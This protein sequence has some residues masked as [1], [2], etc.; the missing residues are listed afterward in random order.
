[1]KP[2]TM[3]IVFWILSFKPAF[4]LSS[5]TFIKR[6]FSSSSLLAI[7]LVS[8]TYLR[9]LLCL[10]AI[11]IPICASSSVAYCWHFFFL[12]MVLIFAPCRMSQVLQALCL[13]DLIPWI[14]LSLPLYN[15]KGFDLGHTWMVV[16]S[17]T[18]FTFHMMYSAYKLN[19]QG[20]NIQPWCVPFPIWNQSVPCLVLTV[21]SW[22][23]YRF[24]MKQVRWSGIP[25]SLRI[26]Q[27]LVIHIIKGFS[28]VNEAEVYIFFWNSLAFSMI[29]QML[30]IWSLASLPSV[31]PTWTSGRP[32]FTNCWSLT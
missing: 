21:A 19:K 17:P 11:L 18:F 27:F 28:I 6:L 30:A 20:D 8:S 1:M 24:L 13:S 2:Y 26:F 15:S 5:F 3:V 25:I 31:N 7:T 22:P 32:Q 16:F 23:A 12:G 9:L 29:Q 4:S 14:Y 10:L